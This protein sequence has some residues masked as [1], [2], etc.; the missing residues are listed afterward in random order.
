[1]KLFS[2]GYN[3]LIIRMARTQLRVNSRINNSTDTIADHLAANYNF[4]QVT[5]ILQGR[6]MHS[7]GVFATSTCSCKSKS[8]VVTNYALRPCALK[9][10]ERSG[11]GIHSI[12][13]HAPS[14]GLALTGRMM[15]DAEGSW[16][17]TIART[18]LYDTKPAPFHKFSQRLQTFRSPTLSIMATC[19]CFNIYIVSVMPY[20]ASYFACLPMI[21]TSFVSRQPS[22]Y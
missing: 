6:D 9:D 3:T 19:T 1:M 4:T 18:T 20:T 11:Y 5:E 14:L 17:E 10:F 21:S 2:P 7:I 15:F 13:P 22:S 8:H 12:V 16:Q